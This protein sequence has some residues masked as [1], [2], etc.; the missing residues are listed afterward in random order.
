M[1]PRLA[2][3]LRAASRQK[4]PNRALEAEEHRRVLCLIRLPQRHSPEN[5]SREPKSNTVNNSTTRRG[6]RGVPSW[7]QHLPNLALTAS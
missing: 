6:C 4:I 5:E 2:D 1:K 3:R 7:L